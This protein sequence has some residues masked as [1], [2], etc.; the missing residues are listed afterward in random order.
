MSRSG[1]DFLERQRVYIPR[2]H[3]SKHQAGAA[4]S[5]F[6]P[7]RPHPE[8]LGPDRVEDRAVTQAEENREAYIYD[9]CDACH[10]SGVG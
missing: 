5:H 3:R 10:D 2:R 4:K 9:G 1:L 7:F 6:R 8:L